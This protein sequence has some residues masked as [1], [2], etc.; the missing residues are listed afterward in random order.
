MFSHIGKQLDTRRAG[1]AVR[2]TII[3][4]IENNE[5]IIFDFAGV[6]IFPIRLLM[7]VSRS[8][9]FTLICQKLNS[10]PHF[11]MQALL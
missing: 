3:E 5:N 6:E 7:N 11:K 4:G 1:S 9:F 8:L 2:N 10:I